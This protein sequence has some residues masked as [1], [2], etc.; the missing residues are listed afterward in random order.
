MIDFEED[1]FGNW[2]LQTNL[3]VIG[4]IVIETNDPVEKEINPN[5]RSKDERYITSETNKIQH[6]R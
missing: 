4:V 6:D 3:P 1:D 5:W 2:H